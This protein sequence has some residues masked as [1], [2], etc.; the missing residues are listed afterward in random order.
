MLSFALLIISIILEQ[1][2]LNNDSNCLLSHYQTYILFTTVIIATIYKKLCQFGIK[3]LS[4]VSISIIILYLQDIISNNNF[5]HLVINDSSKTLHY[6][7]L[8]NNKKFSFTFTK[9]Y[10][11]LINILILFGLIIG[12]RSNSK[13]TI[14]FENSY[15]FDNI[16]YE[17]I[18]P[19]SYTYIIYYYLIENKTSITDNSIFSKNFILKLLLTSISLLIILEILNI[20]INSYKY[21]FQI[22]KNTNKNIGNKLVKENKKLN[23]SI[24]IVKDKNSSF[25]KL[26][27]WYL[28]KS[29]FFVLILILVFIANFNNTLS[30]YLY[31]FLM[32]YI[33]QP[34]NI[35]VYNSLP[36]EPYVRF[37]LFTII[38][39]YTKRKLIKL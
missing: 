11:I 31:N 6:N 12:R 33:E 27:I 3:S 13:E 5:Y 24:N 26:L 19:I 34:M 18:S 15:I 9:S 10:L 29:Y 21:L 17:M 39:L 4:I 28:I 38:I 36:L 16:I 25:F 14:F 8:I 22:N 30:I 23:S 32:T 2:N 35:I 37:K 20:V 7:D 1:Y